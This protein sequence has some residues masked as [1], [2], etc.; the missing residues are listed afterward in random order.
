[1]VKNKRDRLI[2]LRKKKSD[3]KRRV[4][5]QKHTELLGAVHDLHSLFSNNQKNQAEATDA[6]LNKLENI[7]SL[8]KEVTEV[9]QA[10]KDM[11]K[12]DSMTISNLSDLIEYQKDLD[13][14]EVTNALRQ[15]TQAVEN[16]SVE[17][18][19]I[20]NKKPEDF[21][22]TRRVREVSGRLVFD[23]APLQ[24][25]VVGGG[26]AVSTVPSVLAERVDDT[27]TAN[28]IYIGLATPGSQPDSAV[29]QIQK[30]D[31]TSGVVS[32]FADGN[33]KFDNEWDNRANLSY[34]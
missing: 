32:T 15:L 14:T 23:D 13:L 30:T 3:D 24:V 29:W 21:I 34:S 20:E 28:V 22:P 4:E 9:K 17:S 5:Q 27:T 26:G 19:S 25:S 7:G 11:P 10:I 1:M 18:V 2:E 6:L 8:K 31:T 33:A 12:V 16:Q